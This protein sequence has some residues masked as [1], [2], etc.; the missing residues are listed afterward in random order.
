MVVVY[1]CRLATRLGG[2]RWLGTVN[3]TET[4]MGRINA[5]KDH[6]GDMTFN[7]GISWGEAVRPGEKEEK[8]KQ[9]QR[10]EREAEDEDEDSSP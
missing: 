5:W 1:L 4:G 6:G 10:E 9:Q 2:R 7:A 3:R 8:K